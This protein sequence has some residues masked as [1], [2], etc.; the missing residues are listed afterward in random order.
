M[1]M[2]MGVG[3]W[4]GCCGA[5]VADKGTLY[6]IVHAINISIISSSDDLLQDQLLECGSVRC[7]D[8]DVGWGVGM[9]LQLLLSTAPLRSMARAV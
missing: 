2:T 3:G 9:L 5:V 1:V 7:M 6:E 4:R 8:C